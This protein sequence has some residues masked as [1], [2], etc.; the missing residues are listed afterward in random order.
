MVVL[1]VGTGAGFSTAVLARLV[2]RAGWVITVEP[3]PQLAGCADAMLADRL[4][5]NVVELRLADAC[6]APEHGPFDRIV[7]WYPMRVVP[8]AWCAQLHPKG[9]IVVPLA[10]APLAAAGLLIHI[11]VGEKGVPRVREVFEAC[12]PPREAPGRVRGAPPQWGVDVLDYDESARPWWLSSA[13]MRTPDGYQAGRGLLH[14]LI[15]NREHVAGPLGADESV[16]DFR[17]WLLATGAE[18]ITTCGTEPWGIGWSDPEGVAVVD[19]SCGARSLAAGSPRAIE[20]LTGW[21][22]DW[23]DAGRPGAAQLG[24]RLVEVHDGWRLQAALA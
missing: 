12:L 1:E 6:G 18:G 13:W 19:S 16:A 20:V 24:A 10:P 15:R 22:Q 7:G 2:G 3:V 17:A 14:C 11:S 23:R 21:V 4:D 5:G 9:S 8:R